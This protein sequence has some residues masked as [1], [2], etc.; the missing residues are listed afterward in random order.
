MT[1]GVRIV[2]DAEFT[3]MVNSRARSLLD[4]AGRLAAGDL[5]D[6]E[7]T[8]AFL[9]R[10]LLAQMH[11]EATQV[12]E[13]LDG[14]GALGNERWRPFRGV[15]AAVKIFARVHYSLVHLAHAAPRYR[16]LTEEADL[17]AA[18]LEASRLT[19]RVLHAASRRLVEMAPSLGLTFRP[20][21][22]SEELLPAGRLVQD[23]ALRHVD[24]VART[25]A[26]LATASL[27][28]A[29]KVTPLA[30]VAGSGAADGRPAPLPT[31]SELRLLA[32]DFHNLQ[33]LYD[34]HVA[35]TDAER[36]DPELLSLRGHASV[37]YHLL[38]VATELT[39]YRERHVL[40]AP[41][42]SARARLFAPDPDCI[43]PER[44]EAVLRDGLT[45]AAR[46]AQVGR[47][48]AQQLL[49]R[50]AEQ[51][52]ITV[53]VPR[54]RGFHVRPSTLV[55]RIVHHYGSAVSMRLEDETY[56]A[57]S[58]MELFRANELINANKRRW[59]A[60]EIGKLVDGTDGRLGD[61]LVRAVR[62][63]LVR[64]TEEAKLI[65]YE[66]PLPPLEGQGAEGQPVLSYCVDEIARLQ[67]LGKIDIVTN[68]TVTFRGDRRVLA[69]LQLL[70]ANGYGE[71]AYGNNIALPDELSYLRR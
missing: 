31:E 22:P 55:A 15:I 18:L 14:Y 47:T 29:R 9:T 57:A 11:S 38:D 13:V 1:D 23:C 34:T 17:T 61:D 8:L 71:D 39:H 20:A 70:A 37:V 3:T 33:A 16:L 59:L 7:R 67:A 51:G 27:E 41:P 26:R 49:R 12:E 53:P 63:V 44:L 2:D 4:L 40:H 21:R 52:E 28:L 58:P 42:A 46:F 30:S 6:A 68:L 50:Y 36:D 66:Q 48:L 43:E 25:V 24:D 10:P 19:S 45:V 60:Q 69:D 62:K 64:L 32:E 35:R 5:A 54:Y 65:V 56:D